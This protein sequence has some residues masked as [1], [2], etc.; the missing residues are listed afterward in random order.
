MENLGLAWERALKAAE[1]SRRRIWSAIY[2][3]VQSFGCSFLWSGRSPFRT[4]WVQ[5]RWETRTPVLNMGFCH[6]PCKEGFWDFGR[7]VVHSYKWS[8]GRFY[9][10][11]QHSLRKS[12]TLSS[13]ALERKKAIWHSSCNHGQ[14]GK[15]SAVEN[16]HPHSLKVPNIAHIL[17]ETSR[18]AFPLVFSRSRSG[19][20]RWT[21]RWANRQ[22]KWYLKNQAALEWTI[23]IQTWRRS[24]YGTRKPDIANRTATKIYSVGRAASGSYS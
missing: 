7:T 3:L 1:C 16:A 2:P 23:K 22:I 4:L 14:P 17:L 6:L 8:L 21:G 19:P 13:Q 5:R 11:I 18:S 20:L 24:F 10:E 15:T 12:L 9:N